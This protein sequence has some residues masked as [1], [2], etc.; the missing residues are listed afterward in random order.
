MSAN[1]ILN[2]IEGLQKVLMGAFE[3]GIKMS[4]SSKGREREQFIDLFLSQIFPPH[5]RFGSGDVIDKNGVKS[6][7]VDIVIEYPFL[8]SFPI[9]GAKIPRLYLSEGV[10]SILEIKSDLKNQWGQVIKTAQKVSELRRNFDNYMQMGDL[11]VS[12]HIPFFAVGY[13]GWKKLETVEQ[14]IVENLI[15][16]VLIVD[17][18]FFASSKIFNNQKGYGSKG[19]Y[20]FL[21][22]LYQA[23]SSMQAS[24]TDP[25]G[26]LSENNS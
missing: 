7:Q 9:I 1:D 8:P 22:C 20:T 2:R 10:A 11:T 15:D 12:E 23:T 19:F 4:S 3:S 18:G 24:I 17:S 5:F 21:S 25:W 26:Y 14:K 6:G 16:G 13:S